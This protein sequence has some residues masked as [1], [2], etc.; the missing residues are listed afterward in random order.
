MGPAHTYTH[1]CASNH[2]MDQASLRAKVGLTQPGCSCS[3]CITVMLS[4]RP[5]PSVR[6]LLSHVVDSS[7]GCQTAA[8]PV[9]VS[10][11]LYGRS[12]PVAPAMML[13]IMMGLAGDHRPHL[14]TKLLQCRMHGINGVCQLT[15]PSLLCV[16]PSLSG[17]ATV[18]SVSV[19]IMASPL[20]L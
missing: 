7:L 6:P 3:H 1:Q 16:V 20:S 10:G 11:R 15:M 17:S 2:T 18:R 12:A 13:A 9:L 5:C 4:D 19:P 8:W 14:E